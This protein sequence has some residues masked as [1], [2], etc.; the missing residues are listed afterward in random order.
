MLVWCLVGEKKRT[1]DAQPVGSSNK[2]KKIGS[3]NA[4]EGQM[5]SYLVSPFLF[6]PGFVSRLDERGVRSAP[7]GKSCRAAG[8]ESVGWS[9]N[10]RQGP[11]CATESRKQTTR[12]ESAR[13][14]S[15]T[16]VATAPRGYNLRSFARQPF[17][18]SHIFWLVARLVRPLSRPRTASHDTDRTN[19]C[20]IDA[21]QER[22][23]S[24]G[25]EVPAR[26][27]RI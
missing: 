23:E 24:K 5:N 14:V 13:C 18:F 8:A 16:A 20:L 3:T 10:A 22:E 25:W 6:D 4:Q 11:L 19:S 21:L 15:A 12:A 2:K 27:L 17:P 1:L 26:L 9:G 7:L